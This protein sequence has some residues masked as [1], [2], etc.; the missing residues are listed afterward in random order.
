MVAF[1]FGEVGGFG[2]EVFDAGGQAVEDVGFLIC[3][4][5]GEWS[6]SRIGGGDWIG[7]G[8]RTMKRGA[9]R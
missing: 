1:C 7:L 9:Q 2:L 4:R 3:A 8:E 5:H 6:I